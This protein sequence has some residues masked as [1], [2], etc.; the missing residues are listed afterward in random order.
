MIKVDA[1]ELE[2]R[3][4]NNYKRLCEPYYQI[5]EVFAD[6][7]YDWPGDKEGR[8][9]LAFVCHYQINGSKIPCME[10]LIQ[11]LPEK[12]NRYYFFGQ[13]DEASIDEQQLSGHNW[14][15]RGLLEYYQQFH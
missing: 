1:K 12:T 5:Q 8:A 3:I 2:T 15:L 11:T 13:A 14:Y 7:S 4:K 9:L 10:Q 6:A